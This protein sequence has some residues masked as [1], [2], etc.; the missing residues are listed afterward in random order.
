MKPA[1]GLAA[2]F[3]LASPAY[4]AVHANEMMEHHDPKKMQ[5][6]MEK[7]E[8]ERLDKMTKELNLTADQ[9]TSIKKAMDD[10]RDKMMALHKEMD[11]KHKAVWD[12]ENKAIEAVL[13]PDQKAKYAEMKAKREKDHKGHGKDD[14]PRP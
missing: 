6:M 9:K 5:E 2:F 10:K 4:I 7:H 8:T 14:K 3:L 13:T 1:V 12:D 11:E